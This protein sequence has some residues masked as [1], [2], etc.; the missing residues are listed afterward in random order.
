MREVR[1]SFV[2]SDRVEVPYID[3][4][5]GIP[6][7]WIHGWGGSADH[8]I[9]VLRGLS[10]YGFRGLS[11]DQRGCGLSTSI[12]D[13]GIDRSAQDAK[14]LL[15]HL[16]INDAIMLGYSMGAAVLFSYLD[17]FGTKNLSKVII[18]DM[19]P[20]PL[21]EG[22]WK[23]G[24]Y[25]GWYDQKQFEMDLYNM[26]HDY[27]RF[28]IYFAEQT[29]FPHTP[30]EMRCSDITPEY[31]AS[32]RKRAKESGKELLLD[33]FLK[34]PERNKLANRV[35][36]E[37]CDSRDFRHVIDQIDVP[38]GLFFAVPG[39]IYNPDLAKWMAERIKTSSTY[40]FEGC[41]HMAPGEKPK[42]F[43]EAIVDFAKNT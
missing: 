42:E 38:T 8:Q 2:S 19:S 6:F 43:I 15:E 37:S 32:V 3:T 11:F 12:K 35:Y 34:V 41:T 30:D 4:G 20:K 39:S 14:E 31:V 23:L 40:L 17:Q 36:W 25:Q 16:R 26:E 9:P 10:S 21:N 24:L 18:G 1:S 33:H 22:D 5:E 28:A 13:I 7:L 29:I 27:E